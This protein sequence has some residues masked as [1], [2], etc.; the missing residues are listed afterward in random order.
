MKKILFDTGSSSVSLRA[1]RITAA[2]ILFPHGA[3]K[4]LGWFGGYGYTGTMDFFTH[5]KHIPYI[6]G[7]L[8]ILI[9][10]FGPVFLLF[11][12]GTRLIALAM[13]ANMT[14]I[15]LSSHTPYG[16]FMNWSGNQQGEG[17]EYHLLFIGL[18]SVLLIGGG[19][20][21][22]MDALIAGKFKQNQL[23]S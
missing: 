20:K 14:G 6:V 2:F 10:F 17:F 19:G 9:E 22:S 16:F 21:F 23:G 15:I 3:Q 4:L 11:G 8:V 7:L 18:A 13:I 5:V 1:V 12:I